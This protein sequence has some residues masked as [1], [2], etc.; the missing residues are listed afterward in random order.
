M[1]TGIGTAVDTGTDDEGAAPDGAVG[2]GAVGRPPSAES[3]TG[4]A[5]GSFPVWASAPVALTLIAS[6]AAALAAATRLDE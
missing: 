2:V 6:S 4:T 1:M 3:G 5:R